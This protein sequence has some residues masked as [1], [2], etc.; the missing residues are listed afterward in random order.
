MNTLLRWIL[1][2]SVLFAQSSWAFE[3][4]PGHF[5]PGRG[6]AS[7]TQVQGETGCPVAPATEHCAHSPVHFLA[8]HREAVRAP[9]APRAEEAPPY[10][11]RA[12][13]PFTD[14]PTQPPRA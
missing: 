1:V 14:P 6:D 2:L 3:G 12:S 13:L 11:G 5:D 8:L 7:L 9:A 4:H 10:A